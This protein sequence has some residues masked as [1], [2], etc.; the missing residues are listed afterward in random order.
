SLTPFP[1]DGINEYVVQSRADAVNPAR[2]GTKAAA[3]YRLSLGPGETATLR[4]RLCDAAAAS[5]PGAFGPGFEQT[6]SARLHEADQ[7]Y[8]PVIP[9][10]LSPEAR[11]VMRQALAGMLWSKQFY[12]YDIKRWLAGDPTQPPPPPERLRGRNSEWTHLYN[13]DVI[14][15][16]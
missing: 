9:R 2:E 12:H 6:M 13:E 16:P 7:S 11:S 3:H 8:A 4:L 1:K 10:P 14:S 5:G 15:M